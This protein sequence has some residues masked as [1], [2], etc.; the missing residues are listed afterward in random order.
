MARLAEN[1]DP[2]GTVVLEPLSP[3]GLL[4]LTDLDAPYREGLG[5][6]STI[7]DCDRTEFRLELLDPSSV[8]R[9]VDVRRDYPE[10]WA[11]EL[12]PHAMPMHWYVS[13]CP[14]PAHL[15]GRSMVIDQTRD[16]AAG[17]DHAPGLSRRP[18]HP[19]L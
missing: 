6:T 7:L 8:R 19:S 9:W 4:W 17:M 11:L 3:M 18:A 13:R 15:S 14:E 10:L 12:A 16:L 2:Y 5:L 1:V